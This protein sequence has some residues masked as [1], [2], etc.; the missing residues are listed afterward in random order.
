ML[1]TWYVGTAVAVVVVVILQ[2]CRGA[3][4]RD[5]AM[6]FTNWEQKAGDTQP[7]ITVT[8]HRTIMH[9]SPITRIDGTKS[10]TFST[11]QRSLWGRLGMKPSLGYEGFHVWWTRR[12]I[13]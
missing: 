4:S 9:R 7:N 2:D 10:S 11:P 6:I 1:E 13:I 3:P 5:L 12:F 8:S